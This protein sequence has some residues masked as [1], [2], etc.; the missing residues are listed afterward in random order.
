M[1][2]NGRSGGYG[3]AHRGNHGINSILPPQPANPEPVQSA[4]DYF[5]EMVDKV[6][7]NLPSKAEKSLDYWL[8]RTNKTKCKLHPSKLSKS[9]R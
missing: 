9:C 3:G 2:G 6:L 1:Q 4:T 8:G 5:E 7:K